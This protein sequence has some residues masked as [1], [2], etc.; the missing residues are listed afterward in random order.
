MIA[1]WLTPHVLEALAHA[2]AVRGQGRRE[3]APGPPHQPL[4][5]AGQH[6]LRGVD[7]DQFARTIATFTGGSGAVAVLLTTV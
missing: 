2:P 7:M 1:R 4:V 5:E 6:L 3:A